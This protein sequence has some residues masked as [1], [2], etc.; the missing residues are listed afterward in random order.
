[1]GKKSAKKGKKTTTNRVEFTRKTSD[2][3]AR[4]RQADRLARPL[5]LFKLL[6]ESKR[7]T[8][9]KLA[10]ELECSTKTIERTIKVLE[11]A[12]IPLIQDAKSRT[13]RIQDHC[14]IP[15]VTLSAEEYLDEARSNAIAKTQTP[16]KSSPTIGIRTSK[17]VVPENVRS[18]VSTA[19]ALTSVLEL[20]SVDHSKSTDVLRTIQVA[21]ATGEQLEAE[22]FSPYSESTS[23]MMI[24]PFRLCFIRGVWYLIGR[25]DYGDS[26]Q[27]FR[28]VRLQSLKR[29]SLPAVVPEDF[30]L[31]KFLGN[32][33]GVFRGDTSYDIAIQFSGSAAAVVA[34]TNWHRTQVAQKN[35]DGTVTLRF[36]VDGLEEIVW[37]LMSWAPFAR[38]E[39]PRELRE[40]LIEE[41]KCGIQANA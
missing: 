10:A 7:W 31:E 39:E 27:V 18:I 15:P 11:L 22:Y 32:A 41:L 16:A 36:K 35:A 2:G 25:P 12:G 8:K 28:V 29:S 34:E 5:R 1:M 33:W 9:E 19:S 26:P 14:L 40:R 3:D 4:L 30:S 21:L 17:A 20:K 24:H 23:R 38:V 37:W 13:W 6:A